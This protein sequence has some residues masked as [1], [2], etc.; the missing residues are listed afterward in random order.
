MDVDLRQMVD[1]APTIWK[2]DAKK[3]D[4]MPHRFANHPDLAAAIQE[5]GVPALLSLLRSEAE[6]SRWI[7]P[8]GSGSNSLTRMIDEQVMKR[9]SLVSN[10]EITPEALYEALVEVNDALPA[11]NPYEAWKLQGFIDCAGYVIMRYSSNLFHLDAYRA[12][13]APM[14]LSGSVDWALLWKHKSEC[15]T[16]DPYYIASTYVLG[17][18]KDNMLVYRFLERSLEPIIEKGL[19]DN[20]RWLIDH[21]DETPFYRVRDW[22]ASAVENGADWLSNVN[23]DGCPKKLAKCA[24][25][26]AL[27]A[28]ADKQMKKDISRGVAA[29]A[30]R[31]PVFADQ[32][33]P[34]YLVRL[35]SRAA[36]D[37]ESNRMRHCIGNGGYDR[38]IGRDDHLL[39]SLRD[40]S[41]QPHG[42]LEV[43]DKKVVQFQGKANTVPKEEYREAA[44][45]LLSGIGIEF[46]DIEVIRA[47]RT[48][49]FPMSEEQSRAIELGIRQW[50]GSP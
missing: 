11:L 12:K 6:F 31:G 43:V 30:K 21:T 20:P 8:N 2:N 4:L 13:A 37:D 25:L 24:S 14:V 7:D 38:F 33:G 39:L 27:V 16:Q 36:L 41:G 34:F 29:P 44:K 23:E 9:C 50:F 47:G 3:E 19:R 45:V 5:V 46:P 18:C 35:N 22:V 48:Y 32:G 15:D 49:S 28:E 40:R 10:E 17:L 42:T 1:R 26:D